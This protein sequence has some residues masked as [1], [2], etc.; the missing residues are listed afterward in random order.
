MGISLAEIKSS[1]CCVS[2]I[3][4]KLGTNTPGQR[5]GAVHFLQNVQ[6]GLRPKSGRKASE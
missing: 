2:V 4:G 3:C 5:S 1:S 6:Q